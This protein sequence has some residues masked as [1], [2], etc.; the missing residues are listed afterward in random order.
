MHL[1]SDWELNEVA[2]SRTSRL[3]NMLWAMVGA[4]LGAMIPAIEDLYRAFLSTP[5][6]PLTALALLK[7]LVFAVTGALAIGACIVMR[8]KEKS[9]RELIDDIRKRP[10]V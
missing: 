9:G 7:V 2:Q 10:T 3:E 5:S 8:Q 4:A 1:V 6:Q